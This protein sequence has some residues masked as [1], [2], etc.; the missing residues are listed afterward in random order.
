MKNKI[1]MIHQ[2]SSFIE[3]LRKKTNNFINTL[4]KEQIKT[5]LIS[6]SLARGDYCPGNEG[7]MIDL[8]IMV[9]DKNNFNADKILGPDI[10]SEIPFHCVEKKIDGEIIDFEIDIC[11]FISANDFEK[12]GEEKKF[13]LLE[14]DILYDEKSA[15]KNELEKIERIKEKEINLFFKQ[16][17]C[18]SK[19]FINNY[20]TDK[21]IRRDAYIQ[22]N[23]NLY[24][25]VELAVRCLYY[26]NNSYAAPANRLFY[27]TY[28]LENLP[29]N[30]EKLMNTL[31]TV[32]AD[33]KSDFL[34]RKKLFGSCFLAFLEKYFTTKFL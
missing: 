30:Y 9:K 16:A 22:L 4:P 14:G 32:N 26:I 18:Q 34:E 28:T 1:D 31:L 2:Q 15:F 29:E 17:F 10:D 8:V 24:S 20:I 5:I 25:A 11:P 3:H 13:S 21:W 12:L 33:S 7:G 23:A 27:Y 6:G 19:S